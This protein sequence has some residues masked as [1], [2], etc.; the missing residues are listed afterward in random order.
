M[1]SARLIIAIPTYNRSKI[2]KKQVQLLLPQLRE[3]VQLVVRDNCSDVPVRSMFSD[4]ELSKFTL[5]RNLT[6]IGGDANTV[7]LLEAY[8]DCWVWILGDDDPVKPD[9]VDLVLSE[10]TNHN[11]CCYINF[12]SKKCLKTQNY[13]EL[14]S[15]MGNLGVLGLA[16]FQTHC[17]MNM[18]KLSPAIRY[19]YEFLSSQIGQICMVLKHVEMIPFEKCYFSTIQLMTYNAPGGWS[20]CDFVRNC[21]LLFDKYYYC[22][23]ELKGNL[24]KGLFNMLVVNLMET[25]LKMFEKIKYLCFLMSKYGYFNTIRYSSVTLFQFFAFLFLPKDLYKTIRSK[26]A[27]RYNQALQNR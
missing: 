12:G 20:K 7:H 16:F 3:G 19:Y 15:Y 9:A 5:I 1:N 11:D 26:F 13:D 6:N 14:I 8:N 24:L 27:Q 2:I 17:V 25:N 22:K 10:I 18:K 21:S 23:D 4:E